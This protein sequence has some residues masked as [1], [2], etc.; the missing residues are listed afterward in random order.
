MGSSLRK[1]IKGIAK[2]GKNGTKTNKK[3]CTEVVV[4]L[5]GVGE[6]QKHLTLCRAFHRNEISTEP[7]EIDLFLFGQ[8]FSSS[9]LFE[10]KK[11]AHSGWQPSLGA[12]FFVAFPSATE[13]KEVSALTKTSGAEVGTTTATALFTFEVLTVRWLN[14]LSPFKGAE[15]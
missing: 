7:S 1:Y 9:N 14:E 4:C 8:D 2:F 5:S 3:K 11:Q 10:R 6:G 15:R 13:A 12:V